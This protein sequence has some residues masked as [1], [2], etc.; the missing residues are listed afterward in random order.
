MKT[1]LQIMLTTDRQL[2]DYSNAC[3]RLGELMG[4]Y[5][6]SGSVAL[7]MTD[8]EL[9]KTYLEKACEYLTVKKKVAEL[10]NRFDKSIGYISEGFMIDGHTFAS[11]EEVERAM[12][13]QALL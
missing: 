5:K 7:R 13:H 3:Y 12:Q 6:N 2:D 10:S 4:E 9:L 1:D 8:I 11:L